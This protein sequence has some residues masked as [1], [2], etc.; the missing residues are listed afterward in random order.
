MS[1]LF[2]LGTLLGSELSRCGSKRHNEQLKSARTATLQQRRTVRKVEPDSPQASEQNS[3]ETEH[4]DGPP[5]LRGQSAE[6][7]QQ[8]S[9]TKK[10]LLAEEVK[11][12]CGLSAVCRRTVRESTKSDGQQRSEKFILQSKPSERGQSAT[13]G[14]DSPPQKTAARTVAKLKGGRSAKRNR[15]V[16][17]QSTE[18]RQFLNQTFKPSSNSKSI[19]M[20]SKSTQISGTEHHQHHEGNPKRSEP[21]DQTFK[22]KSTKSE[23]KLGFSPKGEFEG[24]FKRNRFQPR[25]HPR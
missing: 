16:R 21:K 8:Q 3:A 14:A 15:T 23:F 10:D 19:Q 5:G 20:T 6:N 11:S 1:K 17:R 18:N 12:R 4:A 24:F 25:E 2:Y 22:N 7:G 9:T 13:G